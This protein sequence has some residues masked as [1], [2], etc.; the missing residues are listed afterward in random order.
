MKNLVWCWSDDILLL[1]QTKAPPSPGEWG[2]LLAGMRKPYRGALVYTE[3]GAPSA[4][5]RKQLRDTVFRDGDIPPSAI[6][7]D[8]TVVRAAMTALNLFLGGRIKAFPYEEIEAG[9]RYIGAPEAQWPS[10]KQALAELRRE[11]GLERPTSARR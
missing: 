7:T 2:S 4:L 5:Q 11:I 9:L 8:S 6:L 10:L 3:G 1:A